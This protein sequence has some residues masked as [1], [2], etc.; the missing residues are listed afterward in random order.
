MREYPIGRSLWGGKMGTIGG[1]TS[2][3]QRVVIGRLL[4]GL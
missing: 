1:G 4:T 3:I 2:Q